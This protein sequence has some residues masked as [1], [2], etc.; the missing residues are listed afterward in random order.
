MS[1]CIVFFR[2]KIPIL[3]FIEILTDSSVLLLD[4]NLLG[5]GSSQVVELEKKCHKLQRQIHSMEVNK[6]H[7]VGQLFKM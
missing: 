1:F 7:T 6:Y 4:L 5:Y 2:T 3:L